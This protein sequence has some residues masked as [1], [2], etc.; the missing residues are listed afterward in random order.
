MSTIL[1]TGG[2]GRLGRSVVTV[3]A[4]AG[5]D[6][7][8][9]DRVEVPGLPA[10]Q[11]VRELG[12]AASFREVFEAHQPDAVVH[13]AAIAVPFSAPD[14]VIYRTNTTLAFGVVEAAKQTGVGTVLIASSPTVI[15]YNAPDGWQPT[16]LPLDEDHPLAPWNAYSRAK[17][18]IEEFVEEEVRAGTPLRLGVFRPC[19]VIAPEEWFGA[20]T[21]QGHTI[22]ERLDDPA[23]SA[24][25]LFN[26]VDA[27]DA[28]DFVLAWLAQPHAAPNGSVFFVGA[29]DSLVREPVPGALARFV[30]ETAALA[31]ALGDTDPV[32]SSARAER[33]LGWSPRRSWRTE[34]AAES[35][36]S[37]EARESEATA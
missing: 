11:I 26:Y 31:D 32:F 29:G 17:V 14:E 7:V 27:R 21:Q 34:F 33:L 10:T 4:H 28:G 6:V 37:E 18:K 2:A 25:S 13:L 3:L 1:V 19:Y 20:P 35:D 12:D 22:E 36:E 15:G 30:P 23:L 9:V 16:F 5:H 8:S 24:V